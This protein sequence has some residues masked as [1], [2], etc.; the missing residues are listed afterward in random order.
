MYYV[1]VVNPSGMEVV[2]VEMTL[3]V[4]GEYVNGRMLERMK[5]AFGVVVVM[6]VGAVV[7]V[8]VLR[9]KINQMQH[10]KQH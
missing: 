5:V 2:Q 3:L 6:L 4:S 10:I 7:T 9:S 1:M 8:F